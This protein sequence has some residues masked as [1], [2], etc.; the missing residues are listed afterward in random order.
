MYLDLEGYTGRHQPPP[1]GLLPSFESKHYYEG[2]ASPSLA[3]P[4]I[5]MLP[6]LNVLFNILENRM[7]ADFAAK[8]QGRTFAVF[9]CQYAKEEE[10]V[11]GGCRAVNGFPNSSAEELK[12]P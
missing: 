1:R 3:Q 4:H 10:W 6:P 8:V 2:W 12:W 9:I 5:L 7:Q 11:G